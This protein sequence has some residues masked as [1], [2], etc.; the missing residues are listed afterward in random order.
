MRNNTKYGKCIYICEDGYEGYGNIYTIKYNTCEIEDFTFSRLNE[1]IMSDKL[2]VINLKYYNGRYNFEWSMKELYNYRLLG[3][4]KISEESK[5]AL[6]KS[7]ILGISAYDG[8][9]NKARIKNLSDNIIITDITN[10]VTDS[11]TCKTIT[12]IGQKEIVSEHSYAVK[13]IRAREVIIKN[14]CV[15]S[16][17]QG[18]SKYCDTHV[19]VS[20]VTRRIHLSHEFIDINTVNEVLVL[21]DNTILNCFEDC[22]DL[23]VSVDF[24]KAGVDSQKVVDRTI[25]LIKTKINEHILKASIKNV[26]LKD[27]EQLYGYMS[28]ACSMY[29]STEYIYDELLELA[30]ICESYI[31]ENEECAKRKETKILHDLTTRLYNSVRF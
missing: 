31:M 21:L 2:V 19:R 1:A 18:V 20:I 23:I 15:I 29:V 11:A 6:E 12:F 27:F 14:R 22:A 25:E 26:F 9:T 24:K 30:T 13:R 5:K 8:E 17:I 16:N 10:L 4:D 3:V 28:L 7:I